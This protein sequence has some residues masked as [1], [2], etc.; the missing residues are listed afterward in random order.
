MHNGQI[1]V[2]WNT[3]TIDVSVFVSTNQ[4]CKIIEYGSIGWSREIFGDGLWI[5]IRKSPRDLHRLWRIIVIAKIDIC[6]AA[7]GVWK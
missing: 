3:H 7:A 6:I 5:S 1:I 4:W 2:N